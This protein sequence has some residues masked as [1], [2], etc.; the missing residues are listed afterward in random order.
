MNEFSLFFWLEYKEEEEVNKYSVLLR[1]RTEILCQKF[2]N[3]IRKKMQ[4]KE[5][6]KQ[7][8]DMINVKVDVINPSGCSNSKRK[9]NSLDDYIA[10]LDVEDEVHG[11]LNFSISF[12]S[13]L[14]SGFR[15]I[16]YFL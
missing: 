14:S 11:S 4:D 10:S 13:P 7:L 15:Q 5:K 12:S 9:I 1:S 6:N 8:T 3:N 2:V 16:R